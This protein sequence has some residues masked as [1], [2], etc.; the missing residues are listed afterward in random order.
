MKSFIAEKPEKLSKA[1]LRLYNGGLPYGTL[2]RLLKNKEIKVNGSRISKDLALSVGD[3]IEVYFDG[4]DSVI[5]PSLIYNNEEV[6]VFKKPSGITS[7]DFEKEVQKTYEGAM[8][9]HRL[10]RN[11]SGLLV[12]ARGVSYEEML[13]A[14]KDRTIDKFYYAEVYGEVNPESATLTAYLKKD[15]K[16]SEVKIYPK[17]VEGSV[18]I[19]TEYQT[20][21]KRP[22]STLLKVKL[23]TGKTHQIRAHLAYIGNFIIGDGKYGKNEVNKRFKAKTQRLV[24]GELKFNFKK[25][26]PLERLNGVVV[27]I[28]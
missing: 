20:L 9:C 26:S 11:T 8:L 24:A 18:K 15:E 1:L 12:F 7:E 25:G 19:I 14:F 3:K 27:K 2:M 10:D 6:F 13:K 21:E 4:V 28:K 5:I 16:A 23:I 17:Q 22:E